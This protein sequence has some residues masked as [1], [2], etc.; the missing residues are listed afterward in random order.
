MKCILGL[1]LHFENSVFLVF[2]II[3]FQYNGTLFLG[4]LGSDK[5]HWQTQATSVW[6]HRLQAQQDQQRDG[7]H[8]SLDPLLQ[9]NR[10]VV[11]VV[12]LPHHILEDLQRRG[13]RSIR[14]LTKANESGSSVHK[15]QVF[16][17]NSF[18]FMLY[19]L[20]LTGFSS[21]TSHSRYSA[22]CIIWEIMCSSSCGESADSHY[23]HGNTVFTFSAHCSL[24][25]GCH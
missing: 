1:F 13:E 2:G 19:R 17:F 20:F 24:T 21:V 16:F 7:G 8:A 25:S 4:A 15:P 22:T 23:R 6:T 5:H 18:C 14:C 11:I 10:A 9:R 12:D 3:S